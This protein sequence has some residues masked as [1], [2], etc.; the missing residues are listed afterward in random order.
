MKDKFL[1][2][3]GTP[4]I[5]AIS[6][7]AEEYYHTLM[8]MTE[9]FYAQADI[10]DVVDSMRNIPFDQLV[11]KELSGAA[12][13]VIGMAI[14]AVQDITEREVSYIEAYLKHI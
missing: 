7:W 10:R 12:E 2:T 4:D 9:G 14:K 13:N 6:D 3:D 8:R 1:L 11:A 5:H